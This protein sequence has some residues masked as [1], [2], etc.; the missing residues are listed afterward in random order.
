VSQ[1][2]RE[3]GIEL[4]RD[5]IEELERRDRPVDWRWVATTAEQIVALSRAM[6]G[7]EKPS[8]QRD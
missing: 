1:L 2:A 6:A 7:D 4:A 3:N 8:G 5:V